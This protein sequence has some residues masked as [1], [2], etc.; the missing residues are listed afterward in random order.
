MFD[1][2]KALWGRLSVRWHVLLA[3]FV[4]ALPPLLDQLGVIDLKPILMHVMPADYA[5]L[6][7]GILPFV[8]MFLKPLVSVEAPK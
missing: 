6:I 8:L 5:G 3:A 4:A 7:V 1:K 2:I